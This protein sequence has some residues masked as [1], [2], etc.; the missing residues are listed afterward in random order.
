M[1]G[2]VILLWAAIV[3][4]VARSHEDVARFQRLSAPVLL[5]TLLL[6]F[7]SQLFYNGVLLVPLRTYVKELGYWEFFMVRTGGFLLGYVVPVAGN[8]AVRLSYLRRRGLAYLDFAWATALSNVLALMAAATLAVV[9]TAVLWQ[10]AGTPPVRVLGLSAAV[11]ALSLGALIAFHWLPRLAGRL[12]FGNWRWLA[13]VSGYRAS[14]RTMSSVFAL[15][16]TRHC[17]NFVTFGWLYH[18]LSPVPRGFLTGGLVYAVASPLRIV[19]ITPGNLGV[20]EW[21]AAMVGK[22]LAFE[23]TTGLIVAAVF[24]GLILLAQGLGLLLAWAWLE[25]RSK[26]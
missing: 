21:V 22:A 18:A 13:A 15:S 7:L 5:G 8:I 25:L 10:A 4:Y 12:P 16:L 20:D 6:Q 14:R 26:S 1:T 17:L 23:V 11:L 9:A 19:Q 24:R 3:A 2:L